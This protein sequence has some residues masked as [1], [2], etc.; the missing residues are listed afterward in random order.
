MID[1]LP[2]LANGEGAFLKMSIRWE[3]NPAMHDRVSQIGKVIELV[4]A[5]IGEGFTDLLVQIVS[6]RLM[7]LK[8]GSHIME[9]QFIHKV[10]ASKVFL[11]RCEPPTRLAE[12]FGR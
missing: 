4:I 3:E 5:L 8:G 7:F 6:P 9:V 12:N 1:Q 10:I 2:H 11:S